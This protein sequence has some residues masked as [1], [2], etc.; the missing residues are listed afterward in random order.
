MNE[1]NI[2]LYETDKGKINVD[3]ILKD[4]TIWLTQKSMSELFDVNVHAINKHLNNIYEEKEL[5]EKKEKHFKGNIY[6]L[7]G[8]IKDLRECGPNHELRTSIKNYINASD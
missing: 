6:C 4:E 8:N 3:V 5:D 7:V 1:S 2:L